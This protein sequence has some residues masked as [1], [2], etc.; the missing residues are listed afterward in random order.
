MPNGHGSVVGNS[1]DLNQLTTK[2][3]KEIADA[4][5]AHATQSADLASA[6]AK[7]VPSFDSVATFL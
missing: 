3:K 2:Q 5:K 6:N 4:A 1:A 7:H